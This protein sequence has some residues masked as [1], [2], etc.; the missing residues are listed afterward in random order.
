MTLQAKK[1]KCGGGVYI[2]QDRRTEDL[3]RALLVL[4][5]RPHDSSHHHCRIVV[6][7]QWHPIIQIVPSRKMRLK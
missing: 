7:I 5:S 3:G 6:K 1:S 2:T 4:C